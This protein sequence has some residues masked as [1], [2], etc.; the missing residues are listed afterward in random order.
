MNMKHTLAIFLLFLITSVSAHATTFI[1]IRIFHTNATDTI[2]IND[3]DT[4]ETKLA[5]VMTKF[6]TLDPNQYVLLQVDPEASSL[7]TL[8]VLR[9]VRDAGMK[10][11]TITPWKSSY[12]LDVTFSCATNTLDLPRLRRLEEES[13][14]ERMRLEKMKNNQVEQGGGVV[15]LTRRGFAAPHR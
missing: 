3:H 10:S 8:E 14:N 15:R 11:I 9:I 4:D 6:G 5:T 13:D 7:T 1:R 2:C 12:D